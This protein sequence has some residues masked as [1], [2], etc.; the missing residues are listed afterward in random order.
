MQTR[1]A[2]VQRRKK[3]VGQLLDNFAIGGRNGREAAAVMDGGPE[4]DQARGS[5]AA[6]C[7][8]CGARSRSPDGRR[9]SASSG[10]RA[11]PWRR[12]RRPRSTPPARRRTPPPGNRSRRRCGR[13]RRRRRAAAAPAAPRPRGRAPRAM[14]GGCCRDRCGR[15]TRR[16]RRPARSRRCA[17]RAF[18]VRRAVSF[19]ESSSPR[20]MR[21]G[22]RIT[23][24]ATTGPASGP[25]PASSQPATGK[26]PRL[27]A[28]RSRRKVG[29]SGASLKRQARR[30]G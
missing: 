7:S 25:R 9:R 26:T 8:P 3:V 10:G 24:A 6:R 11:P 16:R 13:C 27:I 12:S 30:R 29:R 1:R 2:A 4:L 28:A 20:G 19:L 5:A 22:S 14:P 17:H 23:A 21:W 15:A 18:R